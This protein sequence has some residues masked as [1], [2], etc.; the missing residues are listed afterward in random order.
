MVRSG[1]SGN[2]PSWRAETI[3]RLAPP[4]GARTS[5]ILC[6]CRTSRPNERRL[7]QGRF[8]RQAPHPVA[9]R[10]SWFA[11]HHSVSGYGAGSKRL[12]LSGKEAEWPRFHAPHTP[13]NS[14]CALTASFKLAHFVVPTGLRSA[15]W[16]QGRTRQEQSRAPEARSSFPTVVVAG[17]KRT[18]QRIQ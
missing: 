11:R 9:V 16:E 7:A 18:V 3:V 15:R 17:D 6:L 12:G 4:L 2:C 13:G 1:C 10:T 5:A 8:R 14:H